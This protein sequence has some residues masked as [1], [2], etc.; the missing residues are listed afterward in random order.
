MVASSSFKLL[1][2]G[3]HRLEKADPHQHMTF[4]EIHCLSC[5]PVNHTWAVTFYAHVK[6]LREQL[7]GWNCHWML[8][9]LTSPAFV[10]SR[11]TDGSVRG[12]SWNLIVLWIEVSGLHFPEGSTS[13]INAEASKHLFNKDHL[14]KKRPLTRWLFLGWFRFNGINL[15]SGQ[16]CE[17][18]LHSQ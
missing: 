10:W 6:H 8:P 2:Q 5:S 3:G 7:R 4:P 12:H 1:S 9:A 17:I 14:C 13:G 15:F 11:L 18:T 16:H